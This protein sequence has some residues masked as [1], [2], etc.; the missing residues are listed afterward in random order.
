MSVGL[1]VNVKGVA[2]VVRFVGETEFSAGVWC[3][4]ELVEG[5]GKND[6]SVAGRRYFECR[7]N[8]GVFVRP[9]TLEVAGGPKASMSASESRLHLI[10][11]KLQSKLKNATEE[12]V[13][14]K[15]TIVD[16][17]S[18]LE[19][20]LLDISFRDDN[21]KGLETQLSELQ[22]KY[23]EVKVEYQLIQE[24]MEIQKQIQFESENADISL[25]AIR[26]SKLEMAVV[27]LERLLQ[28]G[29]ANL[30]SMKLSTVSK[31]DYVDLQQRL[32]S[33]ESSILHL[34]EQ[35]ESTLEL[36]R[37][38]EHLTYENE[39]LAARVESLGKTV[40][41][42]T[43]L[44]ELDKSIE[45]NLTQ[46]EKELQTKIEELRRMGAE[47]QRMIQDLVRKND[48]VKAEI[49]RIR[50]AGSESATASSSADTYSST[51]ESL[52][53]KI[54]KLTSTSAFSALQLKLKEI[55]LNSLKEHANYLKKCPPEFILLLE[56][57]HLLK[58]SQERTK[59]ILE[60]AQPHDVLSPSNLMY[61][62]YLLRQ[63]L[64]CLSLLQLELETQF[65]VHLNSP[66]QFQSFWVDRVGS[67]DSS[68]KEITNEISEYGIESLQLDIIYLF[69]QD[70]LRELDTDGDSTNALKLILN[71]VITQGEFFIKLTK[72][73]L[74]FVK[75]SG[76]AGVVTTKLGALLDK[77]NN[78][79]ENPKLVVRNLSLSTL[80]TSFSLDFS[81]FS[82]LTSAI[83][84]LLK[85]LKNVE[86]EQNSHSYDS[87]VIDQET[88][89]DV[90]E[91]KVG[92]LEA[93][94]QYLSEIKST[95]FDY[96]V[97]EAPGFIS[98]I[99]EQLQSSHA[100][101]SPIIDDS[102]K[103]DFSEFDS[104]KLQITQFSKSLASKSSK[105]EE[106]QLT[107]RLLENN[108]E[109]VH[110]EKG[111][112]V[113]DLQTTLSKVKEEHE[114]IKRDYD[115]LLR[116]NV[117]LQG[118]IEDLLNSNLLFQKNR[119]VNFDDIY[120]EKEN[121]EKIS[122]IG[123]IHHL[124]QIL[125]Y[126]STFNVKPLDHS[127]LDQD[128]P[129]PSGSRSTSR[130]DRSI[131]HLLDEL[132]QISK[133]TVLVPILKAEWRPRKNIPKYITSLLRE[134]NQ[135]YQLLKSTILNNQS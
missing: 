32:T 33:A 2:G 28:Q 132:T 17:E 82:D 127:W 94:E 95:A 107:V 76:A 52:N 105:I 122:L 119:G 110:Q 74:T 26:N 3:G 12:I 97:S 38:V 86:I 62:Q 106:L 85:L 103:L 79:L 4:V 42:L 30:E 40:D 10:I 120:T 15:Q 57:L 84:L 125:N 45:E 9:S 22:L 118:Q 133:T 115:L 56:S 123:E 20:Q 135:R 113:S 131:L 29:N 65:Q 69:V 67:L 11:D 44:H 7:Q 25:L 109:L 117:S 129:H 111:K 104:M 13:K 46:V 102:P 134:D 126:Y 59:F 60:M 68:L 98:S 70:S 75:T 64:W 83:K 14:L 54:K 50:Q 93:I 88:L 39:D 72:D 23:D 8:Y 47:D 101:N 77:I 36:E 19:M 16:L 61:K 53:L 121:S 48:D 24:E 80:T 108:L 124:R 27:N 51:E 112:L 6:G 31:A 34:Q 114:S 130:S 58:L 90:Y 99:Y 1:S 49:E 18:T 92:T 81:A 43:E 78:I 116:E 87:D 41:E 66:K 96:Q 37:L 73:L 5:S 128:I 71:I 100:S 55:E 35:L 63:L 91:L 21:Q 89:D